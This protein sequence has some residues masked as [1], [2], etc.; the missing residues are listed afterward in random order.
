M[1]L[2]IKRAVAQR[3]GYKM[4]VPF[5]VSK[6]S[7]ESWRDEHHI[8][9]GDLS[10]DKLDDLE[11]LLTRFKKVRGVG[12]LL[13]DIALWRKT[14]AE[15]AAQLKARTVRQFATLLKQYLLTVPG[16]RI[17]QRHEEGAM[18]AYYVADIDYHP[19]RESR[20]GGRT[21]PS[22]E[23]ELAYE[24]IGGQHTT[25]AY[26]H[27][28][29]C[30]HIP[31][32]QALIERGFVPETEELRREYLETKT[33]YVATAPLIGKQ[34]WASG[35]AFQKGRYSTHAV[36][37]DR[38][39]EAARVVVDVFWEEDEKPDRDRN[40]YLNTYFWPNVEQDSTYDPETDEDKSSLDEDVTLERPE[41][42]V[43]IHPWLIIFHLQKHLRMQAHVDQLKEYVYDER[44]ADK[45]VLPADQKSLVKLLI[46]TKGGMFQDIV[47]GKGGGAVVLFS[48]P[49]GTGKTLTAEVY[50]ES[51]KRAL[52]SVQCSQLGIN[53]DS[54]EEELLAVFER[55]KRWNAVMLLDE[56]DVYV[57]ERGSSMAQNAVV[58]VFLRVLEYQGTILFLTTNRPDDVDDAIASRCIARIVYAAPS[59]KDAKTIWR[60]LA[61]NAG[62]TIMTD[63]IAGVVAKNPGMTGRDIK[64]ILKLA[65]L[66][67]GAKGGIT[68]DMI[69]YVQQFKPTGDI[70]V[71]LNGAQGEGPEANR[72]QA[73]VDQKEKQCKRTGHHLRN[74]KFCWQ[75]LSFE[76]A[77]VGS[78]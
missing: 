44:L 11:A 49:P 1:E 7:W 32:A 12:V 72:C 21:P 54:L 60:V 77:G 71:S 67:E 19:P 42:E 39:G 15:G 31:V 66:M 28:G 59:A 45:L 22:V 30:R 46:D 62:V 70:V 6:E 76:K 36:A 25:S 58:G 9:L 52:Y 65:A 47:Q 61:D 75:H 18:L 3:I 29:D 50:A 41:I 64:N 14:L 53:P 37:L 33:R 78:D 2:I 38:D 24:E 10:A 63:V 20:S 73:Y 34:Y 23:M 8:D 55:A 13:S 40:V 69:A 51:E 68:E 35:K 56:A 27:D 74:G 26:F 57:H 16:H 48:G 4:L 43:P 17:Y 5:G